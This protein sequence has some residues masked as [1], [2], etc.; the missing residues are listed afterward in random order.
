M[1]QQV[2]APTILT[3]APADSKADVMGKL[4]S[5]DRTAS[6][7]SVQDYRAIA[8][9]EEMKVTGRSSEK[10][11]AGIVKD[12][13]SLGVIDHRTAAEAVTYKGSNPFAVSEQ[14]NDIILTFRRKA[15]CL[16]IA[17]SVYVNA[18]SFAIDRFMTLPEY[19]WLLYLSTW[20]VPILLLAA[21]NCYRYKIPANFV[22]LFIFS[23][24]IGV[25]FGLLHV[26]M[27]VYTKYYAID[28]RRNWSP[29]CYGMAGHTISLV[30]VFLLTCFR[31]PGKGVVKMA[32]VC[33]VVAV[34]TDIAAIVLYNKY[35]H[36]V[37]PEL[38]LGI[39]LFMHTLSILWIGYQMDTLAFRLQVAEWIYPVILLW[40]EI[41]VAMFMI[42]V[43]FF[44]VC[45]IMV[46]EGHGG[47]TSSNWDGICNGCHSSYC[48]C[49][50]TESKDE[51]DGTS[52]PVQQTMATGV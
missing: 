32:P 8:V 37:G 23:T 3:S 2:G 36:Y 51:S 43:M 29:Q 20:V 7:R 9:V 14:G 39:G 42:C 30:L 50:Y 15:L 13:T 35:L 26:P 48:D 5:V 46:G 10:T 38:F 52:A 40:C 41:F 34:L 31:H 49:Y 24:V 47:G 12:A 27:E 22:L 44:T 33:A 11:K 17:Q 6:Q 16:I 45:L 21:L 25:T 1:A 4:D 28:H 19:H 18:I